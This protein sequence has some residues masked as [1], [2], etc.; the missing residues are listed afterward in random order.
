MGGEEGGG[1][2][3][4]SS[5]VASAAVRRWTYVDLNW[6]VRGVSQKILVWLDLACFMTTSTL[7][8]YVCMP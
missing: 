5:H 4:A 1:G 2:G 8:M 6:E 3:T 7:H